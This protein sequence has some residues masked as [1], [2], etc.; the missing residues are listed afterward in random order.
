MEYI[1]KN[2]TSFTS[3]Y[4]IK[5]ADLSENSGCK[6]NMNE[7][8][9]IPQPLY[10]IFIGLCVLPNNNSTINIFFVLFTLENTD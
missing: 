3:F 7:R 8:M 4:G 5:A 2:S 6:I 9:C 1:I 10:M